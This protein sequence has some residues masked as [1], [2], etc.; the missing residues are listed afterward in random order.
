MKDFLTDEECDIIIHI[1]Q[2]NGLESSR[3]VR[4]LEHRRVPREKIIGLFESFDMDYDGYLEKFEVFISSSCSIA[5]W[6]YIY[7]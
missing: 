1:A 5:T 2:Y 4:T 6:N 7:I 3:T